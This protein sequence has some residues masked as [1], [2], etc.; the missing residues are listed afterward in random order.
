[1]RSQNRTS[2]IIANIILVAT[3]LFSGNVSG[4]QL[5]G[6][7]LFPSLTGKDLEEKLM[8]RFTLIFYT[9]I[10]RAGAYISRQ[11]WGIIAGVLENGARNLAQI[12]PT[13]QDIERAEVNVVRLAMAAV[14]LGGKLPSGE[15][16]LGESTWG[17]IKRRICPLWPFC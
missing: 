7:Q 5:R 15:I 8:T 14:T 12:K 3:L 13:L 16:R 10:D 2:L 17:N 6:Q 4:S 11:S 1:M 9:E